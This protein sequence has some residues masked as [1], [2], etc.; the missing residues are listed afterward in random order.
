MENRTSKLTKAGI[1]FIVAILI[2]SSVTVMASAPQK[3]SF[4]STTKTMTLSDS[5]KGETEL[6]YYEEEGLSTVI[7]VCADD[8]WKIGIRLT[9]MEMAAYMDWTMTKV[10]VAF[11][12]DNGCPYIDARI[13]IFDEGDETHPGSII[14]NDTLVR[15]NT[16]GVHTIPLVT[17]VNLSNHNELWVA[18]EWRDN[19]SFDY[20]AW[21]D[22]ITG[23]AVDK[24]GDWYYL[25]SAWGE[26]Q[27]GGADYDGNWGIGAIIKGE[28]VTQLAI[29]NIKGPMG[30]KA[31]VQ[32]IGADNATDVQWSITVTG[33][34]LNRVNA[35]VT[36]TT[37]SLLAGES[38]PL[39]V[40]TFF[41]LGTITIIIT[42][43]AKNANQI[44]S[45][46]SAFLLGSFVFG[47]QDNF[48]K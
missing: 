46:K 31:D 44:S 5:S 22:T 12:A 26:I 28:G 47:I 19:F 27:T 37:A 21:L 24:K 9:Q 13:Y 41:G 35:I 18:V 7:G 15:L 34:V 40:W 1:L 16:T 39:W 25:N 42:A 17:P 30:I 36:G 11:S 20:Y 32:N 48:Q 6:K 2:V 23:P 10:N 3:I 33:G 43:E 14:V 45:T 4:S 38:V 29:G 8:Y